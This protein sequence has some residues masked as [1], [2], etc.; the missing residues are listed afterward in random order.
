MEFNELPNESTVVTFEL[1]FFVYAFNKNESDRL[2][3]I[4]EFRYL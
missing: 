3:N 2:A 4:S 1:F